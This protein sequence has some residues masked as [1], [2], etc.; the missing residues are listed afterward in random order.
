[1][2]LLLIYILLLLTLKTIVDGLKSR[3]HSVNEVGTASVATGIAL[4]KD[5]YVYANAD[6][7]KAGATSGF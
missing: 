1:M 5:G 6:V 3:G 2:L 4:E 7:R